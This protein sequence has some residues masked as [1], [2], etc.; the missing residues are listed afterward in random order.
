MMLMRSAPLTTPT[1]SRREWL[2][3]PLLTALS[4]CTDIHQSPDFERHRNSQLLQ[5]YDRPNDIYFD[6]RSATDASTAD[7]AT[8]AVRMGWLDSWLKQRGLCP[9]GRDVSA[10]RPFNYLEDNPGRYDLRYEVTC[11]AAPAVTATE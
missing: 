7:A 10:P 1:R 3:L 4:A 6:V 8:E 2:V 11:K 5:S 9:N